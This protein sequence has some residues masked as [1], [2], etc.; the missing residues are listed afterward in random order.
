MIG[1]PP[2]GWEKQKTIMSHF[3]PMSLTI[4]QCT[5]RRR[6]MHR[7]YQGRHEEAVKKACQEM[8]NKNSIAVLAVIPAIVDCIQE[9]VW[10]VQIASNT[11]IVGM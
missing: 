10:I 2:L 6:T 7:I 1:L 9:F 11:V 3:R 4:L 5:T 8:T